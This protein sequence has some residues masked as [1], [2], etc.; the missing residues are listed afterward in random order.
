APPAADTTASDTGHTRRAPTPHYPAG[1]GNGPPDPPLALARDEPRHGSGA[2]PRAAAPRPVVAGDHPADRAQSAHGHQ[3]AAVRDATGSPPDTNDPAE[4]GGLH[5]VAATHAL[6]QLA[7]GT[8]CAG[9]TEACAS[10]AAASPGPPLGRGA[11]A[12]ANG[13]R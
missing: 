6:D 1:R 3:V 2:G 10:A 7:G 8:A 5:R 4:L 13:A 11:G 12:A 9:P